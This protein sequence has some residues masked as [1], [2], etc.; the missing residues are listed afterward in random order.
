MNCP[1]C[2]KPMEDEPGE[3]WCNN[4]ACGFDCCERYE[5]YYVL[6]WFGD[7]NNWPYDVKAKR[8]P[9]GGLWVGKKEAV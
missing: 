9:E 7:K 2:G 5:G 6:C 1:E 3:W 8:M 4:G